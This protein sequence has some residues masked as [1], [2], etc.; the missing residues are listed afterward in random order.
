MY[1]VGPQETRHPPEYVGREQQLQG[2]STVYS[3]FDDIWG[4]LTCRAEPRDLM[5]GRKVK[6]DSFRIM[7]DILDVRDSQFFC[8]N[9]ACE[10][11]VDGPK[12]FLLR[13]CS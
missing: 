3:C 2:R 1:M 4:L 6:S 8:S 7:I 5:F 12:T 13:N 10:R 9:N 11:L